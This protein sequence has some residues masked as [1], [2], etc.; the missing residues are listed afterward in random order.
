MFSLTKITS[1]TALFVTNLCQNMPRTKN[2]PQ[3]WSAM[4]WT[5]FEVALDIYMQDPLPLD[6][7]I[8]LRPI[9]PAEPK[10]GTKENPIVID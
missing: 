6:V 10:E 2:V 3:S 5:P 9:R 7:K 4:H 1:Q 8:K